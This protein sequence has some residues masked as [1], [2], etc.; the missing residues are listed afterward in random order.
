AST[1][2][3]KTLQLRGK[4]CQLSGNPSQSSDGRAA[5][6]DEASHP[7]RSLKPISAASVLLWH[8]CSHLCIGRFNFQAHLQKSS[9][10]NCEIPKTIAYSYRANGL[11]GCWADGSVPTVAGAKVTRPERCLGVTGKRHRSHRRTRRS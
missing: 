1:R 8:P 11:L 2:S 9:C 7:R 3:A 10:R 6:T 5:A 4:P